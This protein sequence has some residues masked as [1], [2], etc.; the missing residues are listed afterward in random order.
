M[1]KSRGVCWKPK[2]RYAREEANAEPEIKEQ[3]C[4][5]MGLKKLNDK[6]NPHIFLKTRG[7]END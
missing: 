4:A 7:E 5:R 3:E 2:C 1:S 6:E